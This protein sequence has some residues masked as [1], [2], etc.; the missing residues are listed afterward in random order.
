V[1][2]ETKRFINP[3]LRPSQDVEPKKN[4]V[5]TPAEEPVSSA[6]PR[7]SA[8]TRSIKS[9]LAATAEPLDDKEEIQSSQTVQSSQITAEILSSDVETPSDA[10]SYREEANAPSE[11]V[12]AF[13]NRHDDTLLLNHVVTDVEQDRSLANHTV[14]AQE[15]EETHYEAPP[16][17]A[18]A[19]EEGAFS[20]MSVP[21]SQENKAASRNGSTHLDSKQSTR[22]TKRNAS[23]RREADAEPVLE[24][25]DPDNVDTPATQG[26]NRRR[27]REQT[28]EDTHERATLWIDRRL[29]QAFD[30]LAYSSELSK[31]ALL[32]EA[33]ADLLKKYMSR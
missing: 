4:A 11:L 21:H 32:N 19:E 1:P 10:N 18:Y 5:P 15:E 13:E 29:K 24:Q 8:S 22:S 33:V 2:K 3:L 12:S 25:D 28:F 20:V 14:V 7:R 31:T 6:A 23:V 16:A 17:P 30:E 27:R 9:P 26:G